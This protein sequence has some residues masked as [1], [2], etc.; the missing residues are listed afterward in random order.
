MQKLQEDADLEL[1]KDAFGK[2]EEDAI[3]KPEEDAF[4]K[5]EGSIFVGLVTQNVVNP[6]L[7]MLVELYIYLYIIF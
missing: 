2:P 1:A 6:K 3:G 4:G 5:P 7:L